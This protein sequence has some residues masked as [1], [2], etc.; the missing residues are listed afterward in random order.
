MEQSKGNAFFRHRSGRIGASKC[1]PA[2]HTSPA[3]PAQSLIK[4]ICYPH[5]FRFNTAAT[6]HG[7]KHED[8]AIEAYTTY[9]KQRHVNFNVTKCGTFIDPDHP[10]LH[11]TPDFLCECDCCGLGCGEVKCPYCMEGTDFEDYCTKKSSCLQPDG[12]NF[13]LKREY[14]Y[15]YQVQLQLNITK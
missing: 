5:V 3:Q 7:C 12:E 1:Y 4:S 14:P 13:V 15:Y 6:I 2:T 9:M 11:A 8:V 10:F